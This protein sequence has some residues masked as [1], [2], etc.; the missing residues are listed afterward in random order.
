MASHTRREESYRG[1][2]VRFTPEE[3]KWYSAEGKQSIKD[4][5]DRVIE[6]YMKPS[7]FKNRRGGAAFGDLLEIYTKWHGHNLI[8]IA[9][10]QGGRRLSQHV[11]DFET[12]SG[13]LT[14]IGADLF[15]VSYFRHT[16]RW[17]TIDTDCN[18][19]AALK[20]FRKPSPLWPW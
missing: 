5:V 6:R 20:Y 1:G 8:L 9:K 15:D 18:L 17:W 3:L 4:K 7:I 11:E 12:K 10:R 13:R 14:L 19:K 16:G 2:W